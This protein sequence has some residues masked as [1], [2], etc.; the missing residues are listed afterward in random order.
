MTRGRSTELSELFNPASVAVI[1]AS[2]RIGTVGASLFRNVL[3]AGFRGV[4]YPV[5]P[6]WS[7]VSGVRCYPSVAK[8]PEP[9]E[10]A[11][12]IVPAAEVSNVVEELG[13]AGTRG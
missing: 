10:L 6:R 1:G 9:P 11:V 12:V 2:N 3:A 7:S 4:A 5:N 13:A 8:L